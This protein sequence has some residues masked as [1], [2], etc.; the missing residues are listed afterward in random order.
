LTVIVLNLRLFLVFAEIFNF[1][2]KVTVVSAC[3]EEVVLGWK[4]MPN[5]D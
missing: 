2:V 3:G 1:F 5:R 4:N